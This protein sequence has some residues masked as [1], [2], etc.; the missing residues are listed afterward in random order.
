M[1]FKLTLLNLFTAPSLRGAV[2][3]RSNP[4]NLAAGLLR[5]VPLAMTALTITFLFLLISSCG[6]HLRG[7]VSIPPEL[8]ILYLQSKTPYADFEQTMRARLRSY[9]I[10][11]TDTAAEAPL[12]IEIL[13]TNWQQ[14]PGAFST[15]LTTRQYTLTLVITYQLLSSKGIVVIPP[16][17]VTA[18]TAFTIDSSQLLSSTDLGQQYHDNLQ[19][20]AASRVMSQLV[21]KNSRKAIDDYFATAKIPIAQPDAK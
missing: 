7:H 13:S 1:R 17:S 10:T 15:N 6:F 18:T 4:E 9:D 5:G 20:D 19:E 11:L 12:T 3:R 16:N 2:R 14:T 21:S 8:K